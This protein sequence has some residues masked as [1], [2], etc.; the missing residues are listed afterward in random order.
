MSESKNS[1]TFIRLLQGLTELPTGA[2]MIIVA[3]MHLLLFASAYVGAFA[4]RF[5]LTIPDTWLS[6]MWKG[7]PIILGIKLAVFGIFKMYQG[8]W[9]YVSLYDLL[10]LARAL[11]VSG[12]LFLALCIFGDVLSPPRSIYVLD[13][14]LSLVLIGGAR[15]SLR[16][17]REALTAYLPS[18]PDRQ[19]V[20]IIGAGDTGETLLREVNKNINL[21]YKVIGFLDDA[22]NKQGLKIQNATVLG[23][24]DRLKHF[25][26]KHNVSTVLIAMPSASSEQLRRVVELSKQSH[27][28]T[29]I[30][31]AVENI[32]SADF[33]VR[34]LREVSISDLLGREPVR[35]DMQSIG[36]FL[37]GRRVLVTGAGGSIG[38]ELC[39]QVLRFAPAELVM[40]EMA[41]TPLFFIHKELRAE[42]EDIL[43]PYVSS[44]C[45]KA[46]MREIF[47]QHQPDVI[48][49]AAAYKHVPL[50]EANPCE[51]VKNNIEGT[52]VIAELASELQVGTF[53]LISTDKAVNPTSVMGATKRITELLIMSIQRREENQTRFCAVRFGNVLGSNGS[54]VPI[55]RE[56]I[57]KGGP[58]TVTHQEMTRYFMTIPEAVQLVLQAGAFGQGGEIFIL[59]MGEPVKIADLARD[60]IRLSGL[61]EDE[62]EITYTGIRPGEKLFE[63]LA[64]NEDEVDTTRHK[65][66]FIARKE[67]T[68]LDE[69]HEHKGELLSSAHD[70]DNNQVR[71]KL[72]DLIPTYVTPTLRKNVVSLHGHKKSA[73]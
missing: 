54:V 16:L 41:E 60:M 11:A 14:G 59:D 36:R 35:L 1:P 44:I 48:L 8:W 46:R 51:A 26:D 63:E 31:P 70:G 34:Q 65:K 71:E 13:F 19:N 39:R 68:G 55:F 52:Q 64:I 23:P 17:I 10:D 22:P 61:T 21:P 56:Q 47:N 15:G 18:S 38:S 7:L 2:R 37:Q 12:A 40:V 20:L 45:D 9:R 49:H 73:S 58:V 67:V 29:K 53:V 4:V 6:V 30:L 25:V 72:R 24:I 66:I 5:D 43:V 50:M 28:E 3:S 62:I 32:L 27:V 69:L 33:S 57:K 42:H